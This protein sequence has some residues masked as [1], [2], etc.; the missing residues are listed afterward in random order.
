[1]ICEATCLAG[2]PLTSTYTPSTASEAEREALPPVNSLQQV[3]AFT[4][5]IRFVGRQEND[6]AVEDENLNGSRQ[7]VG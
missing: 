1:M 5:R 3:L 4:S 2:D 7:W 6:I